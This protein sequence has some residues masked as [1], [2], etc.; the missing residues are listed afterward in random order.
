MK[1]T[2]RNLVAKHAGSFNRSAVHVD[3]KKASKSGEV[4][5]KRRRDDVDI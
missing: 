4:K 2:N 1:H 5:H 3:R